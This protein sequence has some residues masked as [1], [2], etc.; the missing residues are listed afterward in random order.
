ML[1]VS[2]QGGH[3]I[4]PFK[5]LDATSE[6]ALRD[7]M[8]LLASDIIGLGLKGPWKSGFCVHRASTESSA[9][10]QLPTTSSSG[11]SAAGCLLLTGKTSR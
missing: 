7:D 9:E 11:S 4:L 3:P 5:I 2:Q 6:P 1:L 8:V 10:K